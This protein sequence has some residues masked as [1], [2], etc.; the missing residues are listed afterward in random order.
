MAHA[1]Q[2]G[3]NTVRLGAY[4]NEIQPTADSPLDFTVV[5]ALLDA[6]DRQGIKVVMTV[7]AKAPSWPEMYAPDWAKPEGVGMDYSR[8]DEFQARSREFVERTAEHL[9]GRDEIAV[10]QVE[11]EPL[12]RFWQMPYLRE[13]QVADEA[14]IL[15]RS[16]DGRRPVML[17]VWAQS[18]GAAFQ[19]DLEA[20]F[21]I[22]DVIGIDSY[23]HTPK[24]H[25]AHDRSVTMPREIMRMS[26]Q[27][28]IPV[29]VAE[30]QADDWN[31]SN[32]DHYGTSGDKVRDLTHALHDSG[33][34]DVLFWR[35]RQNL[36]M[37]RDGDPS[38]TNAEREL[39]TWL[40]DE[41]RERARG[42][43]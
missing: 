21:W 12:E 32:G 27:T 3:Y 7:G 38:L 10:W 29:L 8:S 40:L 42:T 43:R 37:E 1:R 22:A 23:T 15:R 14:A 17:N 11:N 30:L 19:N 26:R 34:Q 36:L 16:D 24:G 18:E 4:W 41:G 39:T 31:D 20:A 35:Q 5:D 33:Y 28:G 9:A 25:G 6:A 13:E 2:T